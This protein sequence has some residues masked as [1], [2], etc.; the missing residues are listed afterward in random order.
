MWGEADNK[1]LGM[2]KRERLFLE[3]ENRRIDLINSAR[4]FADAERRLKEHDRKQSDAIP[5]PDC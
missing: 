3:A 5:A 2:G 4:E 1:T